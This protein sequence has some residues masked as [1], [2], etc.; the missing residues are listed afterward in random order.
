MDFSV[1]TRSVSHVSYLRR[2]ECK[3]TC[4]AE[5][6]VR[7][8]IVVA[9]ALSYSHLSAT[10]CA[11]QLLFGLASIISSI[12]SS[13]LTKAKITLVANRHFALATKTPTDV[14]AKNNRNCK[15]H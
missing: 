11:N 2:T 12:G 15:R 4:Y 8:I 7:I 13:L 9:H 3:D 5:L 14:Q 1:L 10:Y 6:G